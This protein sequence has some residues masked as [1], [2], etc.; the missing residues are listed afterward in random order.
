MSNAINDDSD[1]G[2]NDLHS[3]YAR[4]LFI[5]GF[6]KSATT[7]LAHW[8]VENKL[9]EYLVDGKK[10]PYVYSR[11]DF[12]SFSPKVSDNC[13]LDASQGYC[14]NPIAI[15]RMPEYGVK[16]VLCLRNHWESVWSGYKMYKFYA[17]GKKLKLTQTVHRIAQ[18]HYPRKSIKYIEKYLE[19]EREH[20]IHSSFLERMEYELAFYFAR[21][22]FPF[23]SMLLPAQRFSGL[24]NI[25]TKYPARDVFSVYVPTLG[26]GDLRRHFVLQ[27]MGIDIDT[28]EIPHCLVLDDSDFG[29]QKPDFS[30][31]AF[32]KIRA[33]FAHDLQ[34]FR[35][36]L[37]KEGLTFDYMDFA[38]LERNIL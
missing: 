36:L 23:C 8:F 16:I 30:I 11:T 19:I 32:D 9:S 12:G 24:K 38:N 1:S 2:G 28:T 21:R 6:A 20:Y 3:D 22:C 17:Q 5:P 34:Q 15:S 37:L 26:D 25:L 33:L 18:L 10:E 4:F 14:H 7:S 35:M 31:A 27:L 29:E 13:L